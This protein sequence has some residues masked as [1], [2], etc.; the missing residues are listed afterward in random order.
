MPS[1][2]VVVMTFRYLSSGGILVSPFLSVISR[3]IM[4][5]AVILPESPA[6][7]LLTVKLTALL[8]PS[9][10]ANASFTLLPVPDSFSFFR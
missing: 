9:R 4:S 2:V 7:R 3:V 8:S 6:A 5:P 10:L 1:P